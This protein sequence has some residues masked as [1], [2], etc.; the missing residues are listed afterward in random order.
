MAATQVGRIL[1]LPKGTYSG[2][3][4]YNMLDWVRYNGSAWV[5]KVDGTTGITPAEN[6]NWTLMST[7]GTVGGWSSLGGKPF[8][9]VGDGLTVDTVDP[10]KPLELNVTTNLL[11]GSKLDVNVQS[12]YNSADTKPINGVGVASA[13]SGKADST[14][15][16]EWA[17]TSSVSSSQIS[18][19]GVDD[20]NNSGYEVFIQ[21]TDSSTNKNPTVKLNTLSGAG[22]AS[23]S[24]T[25]DTDADNNAVAKLR[26]LK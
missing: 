19:T 1:L 11:L 10:N 20:T 24:I 22:T 3:D 6:A 2:S 5:C 23:M 9:T 25:Y 17:A 21:V 12:S 4:T 13:I 8:D 16:D 15:L 7:D 18:F 14:D 26:R